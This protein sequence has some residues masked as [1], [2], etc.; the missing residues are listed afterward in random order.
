MPPK[1]KFTV[2]R[3][4]KVP[5]IDFPKPLGTK[6]S[7][8]LFIVSDA[9]FD[10]PKCN[11][12]LL[13]RHLEEC[14]DGGWPWISAGDFHCAMQGNWDPRKSKSDIRP[15]NMVPDYLDSLVTC[16]ADFL[17][18]A[19]PNAAVFYE[20]NHEGS[21]MRRHETCLNSRLTE[22]MRASKKGSPVVTAG[23]CG[24]LLV[25]GRVTKTSTKI[26]KI[27]V[28][29]GTGSSGGPVTKGTIATARRAAAYDCDCFISGHIHERWALTTMRARCDERTGRT[30]TSPVLHVQCPTYK[31]EFSMEKT[32]WHTSMERPP[33]PVGG[34]FLELGI[35]KEFD[36]IEQAR[37]KG[38]A[39]LPLFSVVA[40]VTWPK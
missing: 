3:R 4:G 25:R 8:R 31:E 37:G 28:H 2:M 5:L 14:V 13:K 29:H 35:A 7:V 9:H 16:S 18:F 1:P 19:A 40:N 20:G 17:E 22:R 26:F 33:K 15:E 21:I 39:Q 38:N 6:D 36:G 12:D 11:Q 23:I 24:W 30:W 34:T 10:N 27:W 32:T